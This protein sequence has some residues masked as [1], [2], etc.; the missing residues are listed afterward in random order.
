MRPNE[1]RRQIAKQSRKRLTEVA[2]AGTKLG[3]WSLRGC[4][5]A[6]RDNDTSARHLVEVV[7]KDKLLFFL[8]GGGW[9]RGDLISCEPAELRSARGWVSSPLAV[10]AE[11]EKLPSASCSYTREPEDIATAL[12]N[13][14]VR[15][16]DA[17]DVAR[18]TLLRL[19]QIKACN[20]AMRAAMQT[21]T[22]LG[23]TLDR[24][25]SEALY[26]ANASGH[27]PHLRGVYLSSPEQ[28]DC[29]LT[30][31]VEKLPAL[32]TLLRS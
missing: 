12:Y 7:S 9:N 26:C 22:D 19:G 27:E 28:V 32:L 1:D 21:L 30:L 6:W 13:K 8:S 16:P 18:R 14:V 10:L 31:P 4:R 2:D 5:V 20:D 23:F 24:K 17:V 3:Y 29:E 15:S 11:G 25:P